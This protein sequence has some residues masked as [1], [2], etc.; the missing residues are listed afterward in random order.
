MHP[1]CQN[2]RVSVVKIQIRAVTNAFEQYF[3]RQFTQQNTPTT[4]E[5][6]MQHLTL[7]L[8][9][10]CALLIESTSTCPRH[11]HEWK[12]YKRD[13]QNSIRLQIDFFSFFFARKI[14]STRGRFCVLVGGMECTSL[15]P[16]PATRAT[17]PPRHHAWRG[18]YEPRR[19][20]THIPTNGA[21]GGMRHRPIF[22]FFKWQNCIRNC[23]DFAIFND[24][25]RLT[26]RQCNSK[27]HVTR[28]PRS[29][30]WATWRWRP[31]KWWNYVEWKL[32]IK[33]Y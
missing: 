24:R 32:I 23:N 28:M 27:S 30:G 7:A 19:S 13:L 31:V 6:H 20:P 33:N 25:H 8:E 22:Y 21:M 5:L 17:S 18:S 26:D 1:W 12:H 10:Y 15:V 4:T 14:A 29:F 2:K 3:F 11:N 9:L 16:A